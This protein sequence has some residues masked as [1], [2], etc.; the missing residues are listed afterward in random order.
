MRP[1]LTGDRGACRVPPISWAPDGH[2]YRTIQRTQAPADGHVRERCGEA[3]QYGPRCQ[4][5]GG[6]GSPQRL[7]PYS[8]ITLSE[9]G[10]PGRTRAEPPL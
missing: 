5:A 6:C 9:E 8:G 2:Q 7:S 3:G 1:G 10:D 4:D